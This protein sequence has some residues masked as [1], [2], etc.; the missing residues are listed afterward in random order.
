MQTPNLSKKKIAFLASGGGSNLGAILEIMKEEDYP[1]EAVLVISDKAGSGALK[2][3]AE[4]G[5]AA[6]FMDPKAYES[7]AV[8]DDALVDLLDTVK[9]DLI[10]LAG[11]MRIL[12]PGFIAAFSGK[13]LNIHPSLLPKHGGEGMFGRHVHEAVLASGDTVSGATVHWV[14]DEVDGGK[15]LLQ[16]A[17]PVEKGDTAETLAARVLTLEHRLY[18]EALRQACSEMP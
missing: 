13:I 4:A 16:A 12:S 1:G 8:Y 6:E 10:C 14:V 2:R 7:N 15:I 3:A 9:P 17:V 18:P 11:Y 5:I